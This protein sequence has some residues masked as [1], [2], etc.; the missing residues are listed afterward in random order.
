MIID[1]LFTFDPITEEQN[2]T[3]KIP[4]DLSLNDTLKFEIMIADVSTTGYG[5][6]GIDTGEPIA[7]LLY[8]NNCK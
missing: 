2:G 6:I 4:T 1:L 5:S 7:V 3:V 8:D